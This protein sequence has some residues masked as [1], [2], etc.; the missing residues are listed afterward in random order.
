MGLKAVANP[1]A[2]GQ[3]GS[4]TS[5][6][7]TSL[8]VTGNAYLATTSGNVGIGTTSPPSFAGYSGLTL[9]NATNGSFVH[10]QR[11][12]VTLM[13]IEVTP[14]GQYVNTTAGDLM[15]APAGK[16]AFGTYTAGAAT[17]S[18]GYIEIKDAAGNL[19]KL[20]VQA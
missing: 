8:T 5:L 13:R 17:D 6:T 16:V 10:L 2:G 20:M 12:G 15:L 3:P 4:F 18:T 1:A 19:R 7:A 9:N 14:T 11:A